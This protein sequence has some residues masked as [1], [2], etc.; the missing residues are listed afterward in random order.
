MAT[1]IGA[2]CEVQRKPIPA[3]RKSFSEC[4]SGGDLRPHGIE[5]LA[6]GQQKNQQVHVRNTRAAKGSLQGLGHN[7]GGQVRRTRSL[8]PH[9]RH[10]HA[11]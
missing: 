6:Q 4:T 7:L 5:P 11:Q 1:N 8:P 9:E 10:C 2:N 3:P